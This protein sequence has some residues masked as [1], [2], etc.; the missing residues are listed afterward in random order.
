MKLI[1]KWLLS[2]SALLLV[3]Y[4]YNGV[5]VRSFGAALMAALVI[6]LFNTILRPVL[7]LLTLPITFV[8]L[9]LFLF[10]IN[11]LMFWAGSGL[12][13]GF[14]VNGVWA[15]LLGSLIYSALGVLIDALLD[16]A[17]SGVHTIERDGISQ[18]HAAR[19]VLVG[20]MNP[21]EGELRPQLLDRLGLCVAVANVGE[22]ALRQRI[23]RAR[24]AFDRDP[25]SF[26]RGHEGRQQALSQRLRAARALLDAVSEQTPDAVLADVAENGTTVLISS[27][28]LRELEDV[29]D[30][31]GIMNGGKVLLE[32]PPTAVAYTHLTPPPTCSV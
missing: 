15:A 30:H 19:F 5:E 20:T 21:E 29:C 28:N 27:H 4:L 3:A 32:H 26:M 7:V 1:L 10:I 31:V 11:A 25:V 9:G 18:Q 8:T 2:A 24:L 14:V 6:G 13:S 23:V 16:A 17:A 12:V 22:V